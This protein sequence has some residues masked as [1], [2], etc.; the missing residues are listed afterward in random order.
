VGS[1]LVELDV[2]DVDVV[3]QLDHPSPGHA[4]LGLGPEHR[5][6]GLEDLLGQ[7][8]TATLETLDLP[9]QGSRIGRVGLVDRGQVRRHDLNDR[10]KTT[11]RNRPNRTPGI[12]MV[13]AAGSGMGASRPAGPA[14]QSSNWTGPSVLTTRSMIITKVSGS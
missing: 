6:A 4:E 2:P 11:L 8:V 1:K 13:G 5:I 10:R 7:L 3:L 14:D 9:L 12:A